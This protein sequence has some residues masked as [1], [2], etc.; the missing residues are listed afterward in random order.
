MP[1]REEGGTGQGSE[2]IGGRG[3]GGGEDG[4]AGRRAGRLTC[5]QKQTKRCRGLSGQLNV[6]AAACPRCRG[7]RLEG[8]RNGEV[9]GERGAEMMGGGEA[10]K[11]QRQ[12][13]F[14]I[15]SVSAAGGAF[16]GCCCEL[17]ASRFRDGDEG[18]DDAAAPAAPAAAALEPG[19]TGGGLG[20]S[21]QG[22]D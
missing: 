15:L 21:I 17:Q 14:P 11:A 22:P 6:G 8:G 20:R 2:G 9:E 10:R 5:G 7:R 12:V 18:D 16:V 13:G 19:Q 1:G 4:G 3:E